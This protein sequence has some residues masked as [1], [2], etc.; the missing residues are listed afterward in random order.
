[1]NVFK[2]TKGI[3][4]GSDDTE[5]FF[6]GL[7]LERLMKKKTITQLMNA[8]G[9]ITTAATHPWLEEEEGELSSMVVG[10]MVRGRDLVR[11]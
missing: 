2:S 11:M 10:V 4:R 1:M 7:E 9:T 3:L 5:A 6:S 8:K